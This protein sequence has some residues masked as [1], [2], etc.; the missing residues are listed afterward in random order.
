MRWIHIL[1]CTVLSLMTI[2]TFF[3]VATV[4]LD[5][6]EWPFLEWMR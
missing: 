5:I 2:L 1:N 6:V 3:F 4:V